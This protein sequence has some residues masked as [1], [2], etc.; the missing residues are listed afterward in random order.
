MVRKYLLLEEKRCAALAC[1]TG[2]NT[3]SSA[4]T[5]QHQN[6]QP[7]RWNQGNQFCFWTFQVQLTFF[8]IP[9]NITQSS[10]YYTMLEDHTWIMFWFICKRSKSICCSSLYR[11]QLYFQDCQLAEE[12]EFYLLLVGQ[13]ISNRKFHLFPQNHTG[14]SDW[15]KTEYNISWSEKANQSQKYL[16]LTVIIKESFA[17][18]L[19]YKCLK[20]GVLK[21]D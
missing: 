6:Q 8:E 3:S 1:G 9:K 2:T 16:P 21:M 13:T 14:E 12:K 4:V 11:P 18:I 15:A 10:L 20:S 17:K 19:T 5:K 7:D